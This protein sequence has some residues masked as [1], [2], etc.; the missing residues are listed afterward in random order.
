MQPNQPARSNR[1]VVIVIGVVIL[2]LS[3]VCATAIAFLSVAEDEAN[4]ARDPSTQKASPKPPAHPK[5]EPLPE[6]ATSG[7]AKVKVD[8]VNRVPTVS[9]GIGGTYKASGEYVIVSMTATNVG[10]KPWST[11]DVDNEYQLIG[12]DGTTYASDLDATSA[13][14]PDSAFNQLNPGNSAKI[15]Y[16]FDVPKGTEVGSLSFY[17]FEDPTAA[18]AEVK[19]P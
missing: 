9:D 15:R 5:V 13:V 14:T 8:A 1:T 19:V 4:K 10:K 11:A 12:T 2:A 3:L 18:P 17:D 7:S 6:E 16:A